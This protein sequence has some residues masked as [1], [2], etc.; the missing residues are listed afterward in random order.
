M[1]DGHEIFGVYGE[2][3]FKRQR[4]MDAAD[5][6]PAAVTG[7]AA[8]GGVPSKAAASRNRPTGLGVPL[9]LPPASNSVLTSTA[10]AALRA[11]GPQQRQDS[12]RPP[13][14]LLM[15]G[16]QPGPA[17][18]VAAAARAAQVHR[19]LRHHHDFTQQQARANT[20]SAHPTGSPSASPATTSGV[21]APG[22]A[23]DARDAT[24]CA[25]NST[26]LPATSDHVAAATVTAVTAQR[27]SHSFHP[28]TRLLLGPRDDYSP[29]YATAE[30][31]DSD[32][33][34]LTQQQALQSATPRSA[35]SEGGTA[36]SV[37]P[38]HKI[39]G[40]SDGAAALSDIDT[41]LP[42]FADRGPPLTNGNG[43]G[44]PVTCQA[45][46]MSSPYVLFDMLASLKDR[47]T[48]RDPSR[49]PL[50]NVVIP[51]IPEHIGINSAG[52]IA[53]ASFRQAA[54]VAAASG[55][56]GAISEPAAPEP[57]EGC[58]TS[59]A[60]SL[61]GVAAEALPVPSLLPQECAQPKQQQ[62]GT[63]QPHQQKQQQAKEAT[64][65]GLP[66]PSRELP[67]L[68]DALRAAH[69]SSPA[70]ESA[71]E[72]PTTPSAHAARGAECEGGSVPRPAVRGTPPTC[73]PGSTAA[74]Q[75]LPLGSSLPQAAASVAV[76]DPPLLASLALEAV[77]DPPKTLG[78]GGGAYSAREMFLR[79]Q[80][81]ETS[82]SFQYVLNDGGAHNSIWLVAL[83]NIFSKQLPNMPREYIARLVLDR[84]HRSVAII[85][86]GRSVVGGI[87]YRA[88][89]QQGFGEIAFCA[90]TANEQVKGFGTRL[91]N[92][93]KE[94][95]K[96]KDRLGAFLTYADNAAV[97]YFK[98]QGFSPSVTLP[99]DKWFG[100][101]KDYDGGTLMECRLSSR[102]PY[103][104]IPNMLRAQRAAL[105]ARIRQLSQCH[106]VH[107]GLPAFASGARGIH[108]DIASIPGVAEAGWKPEDE[109][110]APYRL[111]L[112]GDPGIPQPAEGDTLYAFMKEVVAVLAANTDAW[113]F[114][115]PVPRADVPD[116]YDVIKDP[117]D[118]QTIG[119]RID[120]RFYNSLDMMTGDLRRMF[121][122]ACIYNPPDSIFYKLSE[123]LQATFDNLLA[124]RLVLDE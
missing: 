52:D 79:R 56:S 99:R 21:G 97:G 42:P 91:M 83:K 82:L 94:F 35:A 33:G 88:F 17:I 66:A 124:Q 29:D 3:P 121:N 64:A 59:D 36:G 107:P 1:N 9:L 108:V 84:R 31:H 103:T 96:S 80:E 16:P 38:A 123:K 49:P 55:S 102:I 114:L 67:V 78:G 112:Q 85:R 27:S 51:N 115:Q 39:T 98:K 122:N 43:S 26:V 14:A 72:A 86:R 89:H 41:P 5:I 113:P 62:R 69:S 28:D 81:E 101:I 70:I 109:I 58:L 48:G 111:L 120:R 100:Y 25:S 104:A 116:Y 61:R 77:R 34:T 22:A 23:R 95:A 2:P 76:E 60:G 68:R 47:D 117:M 119:Q 118:L 65:R 30:P 12:M 71:S 20:A 11:S 13:A 24:A 73:Q 93:T 18:A 45:G 19:S 7:G 37:L 74:S 40:L 90:V 32:G 75:Q 46:S 8:E 110:P 106:V 50:P 57:P 87:T 92:Y 15:R 105:D 4:T 54:D 63:Q 44:P 6:E 53:E 10:H